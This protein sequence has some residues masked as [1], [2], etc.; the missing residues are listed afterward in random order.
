MSFLVDLGV[1]VA[2]LLLL[3]SYNG[4]VDRPPCYH[5]L[6]LNIVHSTFRAQ[7]DTTYGFIRFPNIQALCCGERSGGHSSTRW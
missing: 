4:V 7:P 6:I 3:V 5:P 2:I 1:T